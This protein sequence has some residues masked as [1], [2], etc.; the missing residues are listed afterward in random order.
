M[1]ARGTNP[2]IKIPGFGESSVAVRTAMQ[3]IVTKLGMRSSPTFA[4]I[5]L[6][7]LTASR[8]LA[9]DASKQLVSTDLNSWVAGT[10]NEVTIAD[11]GDGTITI[12]LADPLIVGKGGSG[13]ATF[14]DHGVLLGSGTDAFTALGAATDGQLLIGSTGADPILSTISEGEGID[15]VSG[16]GTISIAGEDASTTNKGIASFSPFDFSVV[17]GVVSLAESLYGLMIKRGEK[18]YFDGV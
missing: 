16:A 15:V 4:G 6:S 1:A 10:A 2:G 8:L 11:G 18:L 12:G 14:T 13:A 7:G 5:S 17:G 9:S 3:E